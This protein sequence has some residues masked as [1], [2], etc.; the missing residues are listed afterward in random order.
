MKGQNKCA[1]RSKMQISVLEF[2]TLPVCPLSMPMEDHYVWGQ[3][4]C[5]VHRK[6]PS[7]DGDSTEMF[8]KIFSLFPLPNS[9]SVEKTFCNHSYKR[10]SP[11]FGICKN[12]FSPRSTVMFRLSLCQL[13]SSIW[14]PQFSW[15][16]PDMVETGS[17][18]NIF[19]SAGTMSRAFILPLGS[20]RS[21]NWYQCRK[22]KNLLLGD[23]T[24]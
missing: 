7:A 15:I 3:Q 16:T 23:T 6:Q 9:C 21:H 22:E 1:L 10:L 14:I 8:F 13:C 2:C 19:F 24:V 12:F 5:R 4:N 17:M 11:F 20:C 18:Q